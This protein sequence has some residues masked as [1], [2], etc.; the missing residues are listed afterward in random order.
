MTGVIT[1]TD[2]GY[3]IVAD[4]GKDAGDGLTSFNVDY[5][6]SGILSNPTT[7]EEQKSITFQI[8]VDPKSNDHNLL[9]VFP[10]EL[11]EGPF[12]VFVNDKKNLNFEYLPDE[13][14]NTIEIE[15]SDNSK[16]ITVVGTKIVPE[17]GVFSIIILG[18]AITSMI[19]VQKTR[20]NLKF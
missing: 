19:F 3:K 17:F 9:M 12:V 16:T 14:Q 6:Y 10:S 13:N 20:F 4:I 1:V 18:A 7:N 15:L 11:I 5:Q 2:E 8:T